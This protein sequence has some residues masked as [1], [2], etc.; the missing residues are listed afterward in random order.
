MKNEQ[1]QLRKMRKVGITGANGF[2]GKNLEKFFAN[3]FDV[4]CFSRSKN[5]NQ[6]PKSKFS[7]FY[8]D[9]S[10]KQ[11]D[12]NGLDA[13]IHLAGDN[14][15]KKNTSVKDFEERNLTSNLWLLERS[16]ECGVK[17]FIYLSSIKVH[18]EK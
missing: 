4:E 13:I 10:I 11:L 17:R 9:E 16:A 7:N 12:L 14:S 3:K 6:L 5:I 15:F 1:Y 18:G 8:L 2:V